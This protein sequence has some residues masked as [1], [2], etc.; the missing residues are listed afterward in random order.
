MQGQVAAEISTGDE[1]VLTELLFDGNFSDMRPEQLC[2]IG[3]CFIWGE[4]HPGTK[5]P[6]D[7]QSSLGVLRETARRVGKVAADC[8]IASDAQEY[9]ESFR[10]DLME[11]VLAW[12]R[13]AKFADISLRGKD[14]KK[15]TGTSFFEGSVVRA[16]RRLEELLRQVGAALTT[17]GDID[18][19]QDFEAACALL[20]RDIVFA[21]SLFL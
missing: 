13:G 20:K 1:L 10:P 4:K 16:I 21:N 6:E 12:C 9:A 14:E 18:L 2:A 8:G 11:V 5:V 17:V 19:A 7:M 3:S 15:N